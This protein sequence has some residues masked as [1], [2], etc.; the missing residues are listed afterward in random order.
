MSALPLLLCRSPARRRASQSVTLLT[1]LVQRLLSLTLIGRVFL[2]VSL[3]SPR[4]IL[5][6]LQAPR[7]LLSPTRS[8]EPRVFCLR[9]GCCRSRSLRRGLIRALALA[10]V[11]PLLLGLGGS[12]ECADVVGGV[13]SGYGRVLTLWHSN[14]TRWGPQAE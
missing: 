6:A 3:T 10:A 7:T 12:N 14:V 2:G 11:L 8:R 5:I 4:R 1:I 13:E 9:L